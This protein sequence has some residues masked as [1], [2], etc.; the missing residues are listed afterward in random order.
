MQDQ[1]KP[2]AYPKYDMG[3]FAK[4]QKFRELFSEHF[5]VSSKETQRWKPRINRKIEKE[6]NMVKKFKDVSDF[7]EVNVQTAICV[8]YDYEK[9][10]DENFNE[11]KDQKKKQDESDKVNFLR[12][13]ATGLALEEAFTQSMFWYNMR[14][15]LG[16]GIKVWMP[17]KV[18]DDSGPGAKMK[19]ADVPKQE[20]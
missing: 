19:K 2:F 10:L 7:A 8:T 16:N 11:F 9:G 13:P 20:I 6:R 15:G 18:R 14:R 3:T 17:P 12:Q 1:D 5:E 4:K